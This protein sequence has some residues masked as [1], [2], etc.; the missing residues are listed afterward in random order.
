M[1]DTLF[2]QFCLTVAANPVIRDLTIKNQWRGRELRVTINSNLMIVMMPGRPVPS[3][4]SPKVR[5]MSRPALTP[6]WLVNGDHSGDWFCFYFWSVT[7]LMSGPG[8]ART[9]PNC[10]PPARRPRLCL[11]IRNWIQDWDASECGVW[12]LPCYV[13][14]GWSQARARCQS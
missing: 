5:P 2:L 10:P 3:P 12:C 14:I 4:G 13:V 9:M 1:N 11:N 6:A 8:R 7:Y